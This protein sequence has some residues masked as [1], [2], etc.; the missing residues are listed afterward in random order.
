MR[1]RLAVCIMSL[2]LC[3]L[4]MAGVAESGEMTA[5]LP[6]MQMNPLLMRYMGFT[7]ANAF[8]SAS[9]AHRISVQEHY[10]S[11][12]LVDHIFNQPPWAPSRY[13]IDMD[14]SVTQVSWRTHIGRMGVHVTLPLLLP[15]GGWMD[16]LINGFHKTFH[17]PNGDRNYRPSNSYRYMLQGAWDSHPGLELG[18][19]S[20][21]L[22][23]PLLKGEHDA[24]AVLAA[25]KI[26]T[27]NRQRGWGSGTWDAGVGL[28]NSFRSHAWF[29]HVEGWY[30]RPFGSDYVTY[31]KNRPYVR[32]SL[33][34][35]V[36]GR[37]FSLISDRQFS[38]IVQGQ[39][40]ISPYRGGSGLITAGDHNL[41]EITN[42]N[43]WLVAIGLR[44]QDAHARDWLFSITENI[45]MHSTQDIS[46]SIG[47]SFG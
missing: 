21:G 45:T 4:A 26:P 33:A 22:R 1:G 31:L 13:V 12:Y 5:P 17:Y 9:Q 8:E 6:M 25:T 34:I 44:W 43:P 20:V 35:G 38:L 32:G 16:G 11:I 42:Q 7:A 36:K 39:G 24:L 28:V 3:L 46:F 2:C 27:A 37:L 19:I 18:N 47:C 10:A 15:W 41:W 14:L 23:Y 30:F 40:G 29:A